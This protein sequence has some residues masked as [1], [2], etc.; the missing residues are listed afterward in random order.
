MGVDCPRCGSAMRS[1]F[2][3][4]RFEGTASPVEWA[5]GD[6]ER[7][8]LTRGAKTEERDVIELRAWL[9]AECGKVEL[10]AAV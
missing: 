2:G 10:D 3:F 6:L 9:C 1:G 5:E 4:I 7:T 8:T